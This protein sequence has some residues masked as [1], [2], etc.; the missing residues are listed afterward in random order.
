[1]P[2]SPAA[3]TY[4]GKNDMTKKWW[5]KYNCSAKRKA[6]F[7]KYQQTTKYKANANKHNN[8][9]KGRA[10]KRLWANS[11]KGI[12]YMAAYFAQRKAK[13]YGASGSWTGTQFLVLCEKYG[14]VCL[15]CHK[16]RKL[17]PDHV[18]PFCKGGTNRLSNIQPLCLPCNNKKGQRHHRL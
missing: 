17:T 12:A 3:R 10:R 5:K 4:S 8:S 13:R 1:M 9:V 11:V 7:K 14:N 15:C 2:E 18:I 16:K 6:W